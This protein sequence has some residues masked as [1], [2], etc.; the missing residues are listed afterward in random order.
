MS[1]NRN[2]STLYIF[3]A[4]VLFLP[5]L[6][7]LLK[8]VSFGWRWGEIIPTSFSTRGFT[9]LLNDSRF[10]TAI[11]MT[12]LIGIIVILLNLFIAVPAARALAF[13]NFRGKSLV[14]V[15]LLLPILIP[16][17]AVA[18]GIHITLIRLGL[19]DQWLGVVLVH[20]IPTVPYSIKILRSGFERLGQKWEEQA[21][22]L[23]GT[24]WAILYRI[25]LPQLLPSFRSMVF[26]I[27][28]ISLSQYALT[29]I[30]GGGN[31]LTLA[32]LY[33]PFLQ[34]VDEAVIASFSIVFALLP[35]GVMVGF[36]L[37]FRLVIPYQKRV[38]LD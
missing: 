2:W 16:S 25:Y 35:V 9:V 29:S 38:F 6:L 21:S 17:L 26:L 4:F 22:S 7:L 14:E 20:L 1:K 24:K 3:F 13:H 12:L 19:A 33:F 37:V 18:M 23:G 15:V 28:V 31:V 27:F 36:E 8:S 10:Y 11:G 30:I 5:V 34:S 32:M